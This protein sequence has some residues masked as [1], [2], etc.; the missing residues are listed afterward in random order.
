MH[1]LC[2]DSSQILAVLQ[3]VLLLPTDFCTFC[4]SLAWVCP[5]P[6]TQEVSQ[7]SVLSLSMCAQHVNTLEEALVAVEQLLQ[8]H[9]QSAE[10]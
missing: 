9:L 1:L 4:L 3:A 6:G 2:Y 8:N 7:Q 10:Q 5:R